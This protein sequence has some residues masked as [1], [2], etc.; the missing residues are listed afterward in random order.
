MKIG[1]FDTGKE[2]LVVAEI[3]NNHEGSYTLAEE[4]IGLAARAGAGAVKFQTIVPERLVSPANQAR[5]QQL[6]RFQLSYEDFHRLSQVARRENILFLSTPFDIESALFLEPLVPAYKIASGDN[7]FLPLLETVA[8]TG[9][10][11]ILSTGL[12]SLE[13]LRST[14]KHLENCGRD[15]PG[16]QKP[17]LLH[18]VVSYPTPPEEANLL[19]I[20]ELQ[21]LTPTVGYSDHTLGVE[22]A[23]LA[24]ALGARIIEKHFTLDKNFSDFHDHRLSADPRDLAELVRRVKLASTLLGKEEKNLY[25]CEKANS[26]AVR[27]SIV[28]RGP[29]RGGSVISPRDLT[30]VRPGGGLPPGE[31]GQLVGKVLARTVQAGDMILPEDVVEL[32]G[33][34]GKCAASQAI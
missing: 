29:L 16:Y 25:N 14:L 5:I 6:K 12:A 9:K 8:K 32:S 18:C 22:A 7:N 20:R 23:V 24:V 4:L 30:W 17:A 10:P 26:M 28:A 1:G 27:R 13:E 3:G 21:K 2:V 33:D 11:I 15:V 31:E 34:L 19:A